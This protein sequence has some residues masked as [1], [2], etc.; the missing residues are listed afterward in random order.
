MGARAP[1]WTASLPA[2]SEAMT[3]LADDRVLLTPE[4]PS[5]GL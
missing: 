5:A 1:A 3:I 2:G 4:F